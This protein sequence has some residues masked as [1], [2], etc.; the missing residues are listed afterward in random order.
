[1]FAWIHLAEIM[2]GKLDHMHTFINRNPKTKE[3]ETKRWKKKN[4]KKIFIMY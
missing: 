4:N 1:M 2:H 3:D